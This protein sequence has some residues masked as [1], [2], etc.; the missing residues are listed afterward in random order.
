[1][2]IHDWTRVDHGTFHNF[3]VLWSVA[4]SNALN[5]GVLPADYYA[6]V[7]QHAGEGKPNVVTLH[8]GSNGNDS[9]ELDPGLSSGL[10]SVAVAP[11]RVRLA[12]EAGADDYTDV[13]KSS[14]SG[15][16]RNAPGR[17]CAI[18]IPTRSSRGST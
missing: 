9:N 5:A 18:R 14:T 3:H 13:Q 15:G 2:P 12:M 4:L 7:E 6:M 10:T 8:A 1:M 11:P 16:R 17:H